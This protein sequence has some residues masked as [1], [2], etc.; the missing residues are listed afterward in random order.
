MRKN[1][2]DKLVKRA[3]A[4]LAG[5]AAGIGILLG[6]LFDTADDLFPDEERRADR[7]EASGSVLR[8]TAASGVTHIPLPA[9]LTRMDRLRLWIWNLP[10]FVRAAV[11]LPC[12]AIG[13]GVIA[14]VKLLTA[15]I[16][17]I[18]AVFVEF[19]LQALVLFGLFILLY[20][21][22]FPNGKLKDLFQKG[23]WLWLLGGAL[24]LT[25]ADRVLLYALEDWLW[26]RILIGAAAALLVI[27]LV[28][29]RLFRKHAAPEMPE[30]WI[31]IPY[32]A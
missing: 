25:A 16:S 18:A 22:L 11:L 28:W 10:A 6:G 2:G 13:R 26:I 5:F 21:L 1:R 29:N 17:P 24:L 32:V 27:M 19:L 30:K 8:E 14:L 9:E 12:W 31:E 20:R 7:A 23:R 15:A 3:A 4:G